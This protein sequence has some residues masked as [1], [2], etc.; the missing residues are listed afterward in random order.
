[1]VSSVLHPE[2]G[3]A[4]MGAY[5][6]RHDGPRHRFDQSCPPIESER[7]QRDLRQQ[8]DEI[9]KLQYRLNT[10]ERVIEVAARLLNGERRAK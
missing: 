2:I 9:R 8:R 6:P 1:M 4:S 3:E 5:G 10:L 7:Y